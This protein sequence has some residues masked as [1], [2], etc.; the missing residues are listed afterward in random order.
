VGV[1]SVLLYSH[2]LDK[3]HEAVSFLAAARARG[4]TAILFL[5]GPALRAFIRNRW[6]PPARGAGPI[7]G[8][9]F[10]HK[11]PGE[12]LAELRGHGKILVYACSAWVRQS[13]LDGGVVA[14][15]VDAV[16]GLNAFLSQ[17]SG[18]PLLNF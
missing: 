17:A 13:K 8:F 15:R 18:G 5:R 16:V 12:I 6:A 10:N 4:D 9:H 2:T 11:T 7:G 1:F 14:S 3:F